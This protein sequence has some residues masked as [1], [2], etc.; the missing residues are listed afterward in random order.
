MANTNLQE[1]IA[2]MKKKFEARATGAHGDLFKA[3]TKACLIIEAEAKR[4]MTET[5]ID[6]SKSYGKH[7]HHPS[8]AGSPPAVDTG[9]LRK[10]I[11]HDVEQDGSRVVGRVGSTIGNPPYGAYLEYGTS[12]MAARPWLQPALKKNST[13]IEEL[14]K[15]SVSGR[16]VSYGLEGASLGVGA[17]DAAG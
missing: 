5:L 7:N 3:V 2:S 9:M 1:Q 6:G 14:I 8:M 13:K 12:K 10:S 15:G 17:T 4:G 16:D 11:T